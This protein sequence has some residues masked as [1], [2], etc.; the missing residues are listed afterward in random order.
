MASYLASCSR[1]DYSFTMATVS[2]IS[3]RIACL[4]T[5]CRHTITRDT[6]HTSYRKE[7]TYY[8]PSGRR[9]VCSIDESVSV[10]GYS[11]APGSKPSQMPIDA[12]HL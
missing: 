1:D 2:R 6:S 12:D 3:I 10:M 8:M 9:Y 11:K 4:A 5:H 7:V